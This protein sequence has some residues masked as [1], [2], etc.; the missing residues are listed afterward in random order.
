MDIVPTVS[1]LSFE[2]DTIRNDAPTLLLHIGNDNDKNDK[3]TRQKKTRLP[4]DQD[5]PGTTPTSYCIPGTTCL[6]SSPSGK[7][8]R[9]TRPSRVCGVYQVVWLY[10]EHV[11]A[12]LSCIQ[13]VF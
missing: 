4:R 5:I 2:N 12:A 6:R 9:C 3:E 10:V 11:R 7:G 13:F 8:I 1:E